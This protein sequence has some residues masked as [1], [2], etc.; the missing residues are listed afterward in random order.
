MYGCL[1]RM[2]C[3]GT[4]ITM[5]RQRGL[6]HDIVTDARKTPIRSDARDQSLQTELSSQCLALDDKYNYVME[7]IQRL[8]HD[9]RTCDKGKEGAPCSG[10]S[11]P[12]SCDE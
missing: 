9:L 12:F 2:V 8:V 7:D 5:S 6:S 11:G 1:R 4:P 3:R 10:E